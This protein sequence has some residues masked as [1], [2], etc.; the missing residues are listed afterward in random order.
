MSNKLKVLPTYTKSGD[1]N[2]S[3]DRYELLLQPELRPKR[4]LDD[5]H[6]TYPASSDVPSHSHSDESETRTGWDGKENKVG[7]PLIAR[8]L[9]LSRGRP[10][11]PRQSDG[12]TGHAAAHTNDEQDQRCWVRDVLVGQQA[13]HLAYLIGLLPFKLF[14]D[15]HDTLEVSTRSSLSGAASID[16]AQNLNRRMRC[17][18][19]LEL[20]KEEDGDDADSSEANRLTARRTAKM[21]RVVRRHYID[22]FRRNLDKCE[23][24]ALRNVF[25]SCGDIP[26]GGL[27]HAKS[28]GDS[29]SAASIAHQFVHTGKEEHDAIDAEISELRQK[30]VRQKLELERNRK[31]THGVGSA[32]NGSLDG[33]MN[34]P[35]HT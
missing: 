16:V 32:K 1:M 24:W 5:G 25:T 26:L 18:R 23:L 19:R 6:Q 21:F 27:L 34:A 2:V 11:K 17:R 15:I 14:S 35:T 20:E 29:G 13:G 31:W 4:Q 3:G 7:A 9:R 22:S 30:L 12:D 33:L 8:K 28:A 10:N